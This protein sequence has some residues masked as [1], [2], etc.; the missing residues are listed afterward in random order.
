LVGHFAEQ[1]RGDARALTPELLARWERDAWPGNVRELRNAVARTLALGELPIAPAE[2]E[3]EAPA[4]SVDMHDFIES[5]LASRL[6]LV[7]ARARVVDHFER[8]YV[9]RVLDEHGGNVVR[10]AEASGIAR[11]HF[12][13]LRARARK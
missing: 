4:Q 2:D 1:L 10:A 7:Q 6:P 8:R 12:H 13:R 9:E 5:V 11:R 3:G